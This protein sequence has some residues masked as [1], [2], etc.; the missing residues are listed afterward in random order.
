MATGHI[1]K[2]N[3]QD[4][5]YNYQITVE[6]E[7]DPITGKRERKYKTV[8]GT[9]KD[10]ER[11]MRQMIDEMESGFSK[12]PSNMRLSDWM[13]EWLTLYLPNIEETTRNGYEERINRTLTPYLGKISLK[14]LTT[15][16]IQ[17]WVNTLNKSLA[18]KTVKNVYLNLNAALKKAVLLRMI[19]Y[20]PCDGVVLPKLQKY[21]AQVY[22]QQEIDELLKIAKKTD[23]F[24]PIFLELSIGLRRGELLALTWG[25]VNFKKKEI[26]INKSRFYSKEGFCKTKAPKTISGNRK[27]SVGN[28]VIK[29][30][31]KAQLKQRE[32]MLALGKALSS[33]DPVICKEDGTA[34]HPDAMTKKWERFLQK[35][36][37]KKIRFHDLRHTNATMMIGAGINTKTVQTRL[38]HSDISTTMNIYVHNTKQ[39]DQSAADQLDNILAI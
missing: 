21:Q 35:N 24:L 17:Q 18:P 23:M 15:Q 16:N 26:N 25:D 6:G 30:L 31:K 22:N 4:G 19:P 5:S 7:R 29:E 10:A 1:R 14:S 39:M 34:Y 28:S 27:I 11:E 32:K 2:R 13:D 37:F 33:N 12:K 38:G 8:H 3:L 9:K 36:N 20:N